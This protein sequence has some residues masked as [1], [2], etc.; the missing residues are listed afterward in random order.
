MHEV[1]NFTVYNS[2][3]KSCCGCR[4]ELSWG[5]TTQQSHLSY[6]HAATLVVAVIRT[7]SFKTW[8]IF[9]GGSHHASAMEQNLCRLL[10]WVSCMSLCTQL[11]VLAQL[12]SRYYAPAAY[13]ECCRQNTTAVS[14]T[15]YTLWLSFV[16]IFHN[17]CHSYSPYKNLTYNPDVAH[18]YRIKLQC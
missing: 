3:Y 9:R 14:R 18:A 10:R 17:C 1:C 13:P 16:A 2:A 5:S 7:Q 4:E 15:I 12:L 11:L 6:Q 8:S